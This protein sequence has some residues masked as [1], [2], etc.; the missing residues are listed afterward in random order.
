M[1]AISTLSIFFLL[2]TASAVLAQTQARDC[3]SAQ[4]GVVI[5]TSV[6]VNCL[7]LSKEQ[8]E[9]LKEALTQSG[10]LARAEQG[11]IAPSFVFRLAEQLRPGENFNIEQAKKEIE[12]AVVVAVKIRHEGKEITGDA[13]LDE[14]R[15][16]IAERTKAEDFKGATAAAEQG[17]DEWE[18][19]EA[20]ERAKETQRRAEAT[21]RG[22][23]LLE[24]ALQTDLLRFDVEAAAGRVEKIVALEHEGDRKAQFEAMQTRYFPYYNLGVENG[25]NFAL[26]VAIALARRE[27]ALAQGSVQ[28]GTALN[29]LGNALQTLGGR[30]SGT[31]TLQQAV[32]SY[33]EALKEFTRERS[34]LDWAETQD[35]LGTTLARIGARESGTETL[36]AAVAAY[37]ELLEEGHHIPDIVLPN[38]LAPMHNNLGNALV[39]IGARESGTSTLQEAVAAYREALKEYKREQFPLEW[40]STQNN[41]GNAFRELG[42][43]ESGAAT[44]QRAITAYR[45]ALKEN[46]RERVPLDWAMTQ[47]NIGIALTTIGERESG[48]ATLQQAIAAYGEALKERTRE[49]VPLDW[50]MSFGDQGVAMAL[51]ADRKNDRAMVKTAFEQI[52]VAYEVLKSGGHAPGEEHFAKQFEVGWKK[53]SPTDRII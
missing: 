49:R 50:A 51:V 30:E 52:K 29:D 40:A 23:A 44:L 11:G 17:F 43:R 16:R 21:K 34:P 36:R 31:T 18:K 9:A 15:R 24:A 13:L 28:R 46:T 20:A 45:E 42:E 37:R 38:G 19:A 39:R 47:N 4:S 14:V 12:A 33:R 7:T 10:Q 32:T 8:L 25:I 48:T 3:S 5:G 1:K 41:L 26:Q 27:A 22:V 35:N 53:R 2:L 6:T